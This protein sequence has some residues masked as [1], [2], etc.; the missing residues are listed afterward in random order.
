[1]S[2]TPPIELYTIIE[3]VVDEIRETN[4]IAN[5][6]ESNSVYTI[7]SDNALSDND[8]I[9]IDET[10]YK[11]SNTSDTQFTIKATTGLDFTNSTWKANAPYFMCEKES[12]AGN[13]LTEK[14][15]QE[16]YKWQKYPLFLLARPYT[17]DRTDRTIGYS[18]D[19]TL[20]IITDTKSDYWA[21]DRIE[22]NFEPILYPLFNSFMDE[23]PNNR[24][25]KEK[26]RDLI[27]HTKTDLMFV[28]GNPFPDKMD[29][30][31]IQFSNLEILR[32]TQ[33]CEPTIP[34]NYNL[35]LSAE[36]GGTTVPEPGTYTYN[37]G[38]VAAIYALADANYQFSQW[39]INGTPNI[40]NPIGLS[41][42]QNYTCVAEFTSMLVVVQDV[43]ST[44]T[45]KSGN[46][47]IVEDQ[48]GNNN[49]ITYK[50]TQIAKFNGISSYVECGNDASIFQSLGAYTWNIICY[51]DSTI[52]IDQEIVTNRNTQNSFLI[53]Y[54]SAG[55]IVFAAETQT[56]SV[57]N[58]NI[59]NPNPD[60][61]VL[62]TIVYDGATV[63]LLQNNSIIFQ[64][65][66]TGVTYSDAVV[67]LLGKQ[68]SPFNNRYFASN[69]SFV[70]FHDRA[71]TTQELTDL[72]NDMTV[73]SSGKLIE[74]Y[75]DSGGV[76]GGDKIYNRASASNPLIIKGATLTDFWSEKSDIHIPALLKY[77]FE[78]YESD[79]VPGD[80]IR[81]IF[82]NGTPQTPAISGY[83]KIAEIPADT[84]GNSGNTVDGI[85]ISG[86]EIG[87][88]FDDIIALENSGTIEITK[89]S[90]Y[91]SRLKV[92]A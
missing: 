54:T 20:H 53:R 31:T 59:T 69:M 6:S 7:T 4:T 28:D 55:V 2:Y 76:T 17:D 80:Y 90:D 13:I 89:T 62:F 11:V 33:T 52:G 79:T 61:W 29:G 39:L 41:M 9:T 72:Y 23:L 83:T 81:V 47:W 10:Q 34:I 92:K 86:L 63:K 21:N 26:K 16:N 58:L 64:D 1:M 65:N 5:S 32:N 68:G 49:D 25:V 27:A 8:Y 73:P 88:T 75:F 22:N 87:A 36:T 48:S 91:V 3:S 38:D 85:Q 78:L 74:A 71:L 67:S 56:D 35:T 60:A 82:A 14:N 37:K 43:F 57:L 40:N 45:V 42:R 30:I 66:L 19:F 12:K 44:T 50:N 15:D 24:W 70:S 46:N 84:F 18:S 51:L 77:G